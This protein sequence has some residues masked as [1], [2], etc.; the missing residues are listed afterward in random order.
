LTLLTSSGS[1]LWFGE[2][3]ENPP[4]ANTQRLPHAIQSQNPKIGYFESLSEFINV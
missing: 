2:D 4:E 3:Y 1:L